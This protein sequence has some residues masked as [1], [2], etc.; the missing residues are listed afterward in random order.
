V[1]TPA[2][3][4]FLACWYDARALT[5][6]DW[7]PSILMAL[8]DGPLHYREIKSIVSSFR[9]SDRRTLRPR[10]FHESS[11]SRTLSR[12]TDDSLLERH[13][14]LGA[15]PPSVTYSLTPAARAIVDAVVPMAAWAQHNRA[16]IRK[17]QSTA[18]SS[19]ID[20]TD[21]VRRREDEA[22]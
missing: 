18:E 7:T 1:L 5:A 12:M 19:P 17:A 14:C 11:L 16:M 21:D 6:A 15:F 10:T 8:L 4:D 22:S 13:E 9:V 3:D 2:D 20:R